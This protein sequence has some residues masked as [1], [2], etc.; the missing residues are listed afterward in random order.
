MHYPIIHIETIEGPLSLSIQFGGLVPGWNLVLVYWKHET[1]GCRMDDQ[2][3]AVWANGL[4]ATVAAFV[5]ATATAATSTASTTTAIAT[6]AV[7]F[8]HSR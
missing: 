2:L 3:V 6:A 4:G 5:T 8:G 7:T 1:I